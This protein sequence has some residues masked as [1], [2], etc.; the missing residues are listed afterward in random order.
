[1]NDLSKRG[2]W[3]NVRQVQNLYY[4]TTTMVADQMQ[5]YVPG[6]DRDQLVRSLRHMLARRQRRWRYLPALARAWGLPEADLQYGDFTQFDT[7]EAFEN[8]YGFNVHA[9]LARRRAQHEVSPGAVLFRWKH[10]VGKLAHAREQVTG[11]PCRR[12]T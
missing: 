2:L 8:A 11:R 12:R 6:V 3:R 4:W 5:P 10:W 9:M 7:R 1:M